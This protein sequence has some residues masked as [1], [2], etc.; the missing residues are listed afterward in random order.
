VQAVPALGAERV[1]AELLERRRTEDLRRN[2]ELLGEQLLRRKDLLQDR[3]RSHERRRDGL[4]AQVGCVAE[5]VQALHDRLVDAVGHRRLGI[6]LVVE[7]D[8]VEDILARHVH[9]LDAAADDRR[10]LIGVR[11]VVGEDV[12]DGRRRGC[13]E[14]PSSCW[15]PSPVS[16]VRPA[17]PPSRK[18]RPRASR[19]AQIWSPVRWKPNIE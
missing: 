16:V 12:R 15:R 14:C 3:A 11:R 4:R 13:G 19:S 9:P 7:R 8:V 5:S 17:V 18:P 2:A 1:A 6:V 10:E